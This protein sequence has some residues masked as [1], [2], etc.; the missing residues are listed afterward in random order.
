MNQ[1]RASQGDTVDFIAWRVYGT[2]GSQVVEQ[3]LE[4]NPGLADIGP[5]LPAGTLVNCPEIDTTQKA[6]GTRLWD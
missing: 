3:L 4:A 1:Y 5:V 6:Q 2:Q